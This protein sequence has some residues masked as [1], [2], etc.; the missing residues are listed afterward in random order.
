MQSPHKDQWLLVHHWKP[1]TVGTSVIQPSINAWVSAF[2]TWTE[3]QPLSFLIFQAPAPAS[4]IPGANLH[5]FLDISLCAHDKGRAEG[6]RGSLAQGALATMPLIN[7]TLNLFKGGQAEKSWK[8][9]S[10]LPIFPIFYLSSGW[11]PPSPC[12][13]LALPG[14]VLTLAPPPQG[15]A[16]LLQ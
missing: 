2:P 3:R 10:F 11:I 9:S 4:P 6:A 5:T 8:V 1:L 14:S 13:Q 7:L 15:Q 16:K 12:P